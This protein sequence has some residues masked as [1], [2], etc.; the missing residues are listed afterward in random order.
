MRIGFRSGKE[1]K[2]NNNK[3]HDCLTD[4]YS[5]IMINSMLKKLH[6]SIN[7]VLT[8]CRGVKI[9]VEGMKKI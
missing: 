2:L 8:V 9:K 3:H 6:I 5:R 4:E 1:R 7:S